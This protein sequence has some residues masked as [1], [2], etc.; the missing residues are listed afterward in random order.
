MAASIEFLAVITIFLKILTVSGNAETPILNVKLPNLRNLSGVIYLNFSAS[1]KP[2]RKSFSGK[3]IPKPFSSNFAMTFPTEAK[4][5]QR[6][7]IVFTRFL[8]SSILAA[9]LSS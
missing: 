8:R 6:G 1:P 2:E 9:S 4:D 3:N 5:N 7:A